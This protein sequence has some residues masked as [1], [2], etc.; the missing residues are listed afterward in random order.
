M[1]PRFGPLAYQLAL[2]GQMLHQQ[3]GH[4]GYRRETLR[5]AT[6][7]QTVFPFM[8]WPYAL[9]AL[10]E[11]NPRRRQLAGCRA[12]FLDPKSHFL[13]RAAVPGLSASACKPALW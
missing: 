8:A 2:A 3:T 12:Q 5:L 7:Y 1:L 6:A 11:K 10:L 9:E 13:Q 4:E